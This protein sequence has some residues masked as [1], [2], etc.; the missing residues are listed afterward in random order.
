MAIGWYERYSAEAP[1]GAWVAEALGR[2]MV[3][4]KKAGAHDAAIEAA[5]Q[6]LAR[7]PRVRTRAWPAK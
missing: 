6:Y 4:L 7:F 5:R 2:R 3:L 1:G